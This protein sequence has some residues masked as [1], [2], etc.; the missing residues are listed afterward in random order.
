M[1]SP[2]G[3]TDAAVD[4]ESATAHAASVPVGGV[5]SWFCKR[6][7]SSNP[8]GLLSLD[9]LDSSL[10]NLGI[11][12]ALLLSFNV[13]L[14]FAFDKTSLLKS[15]TVFLFIY[16]CKAYRDLAFAHIDRHYGSNFT[17][18]LSLQGTA[19][20]AVEG[21]LPALESNEDVSNGVLNTRAMLSKL[22]GNWWA[23]SRVSEI[24]GKH[25]LAQ[26][27]LRDGILPP[28]TELFLPATGGSKY[29]LSTGCRDR[30]SPFFDIGSWAGFLLICVVLASVSFHLA[31]ALT[32]ARKDPFK[33][34]LFCRLM[35]PVLAIM[36]AFLFL[37]VVCF[38]FQLNAALY[39]AAPYKATADYHA[40]LLN[41]G[42]TTVL[43]VTM[44]TAVWIMRFVNKKGAVA[45]VRAKAALTTASTDGGGNTD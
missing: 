44:T 45:E 21:V 28:L 18:D 12:A 33:G 11:V 5:C 23:N 39:L 22:D 40:K 7:I 2:E 32:N 27:T 38:G 30:S 16:D 37:G 36:T 43:I 20:T 25:V 29:D 26:D 19:G 24:A 6:F 41:T 9:D 42:L 10:V 34:A 35:V 8:S 15:D 4:D 3:A 17:W 31:M 14:C 1:V 13:G